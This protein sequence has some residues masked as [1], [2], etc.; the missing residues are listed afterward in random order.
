MLVGLMGATI[1]PL[2]ASKY[3]QKSAEG[4]NSRHQGSYFL[5]S[6]CNFFVSYGELINNQPWTDLIMH[7]FSSSWNR[8]SASIKT[9]SFVTSPYRIVVNGA[10]LAIET[11]NPP[12][13]DIKSLLDRLRSLQIDLSARLP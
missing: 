8:R 4:A 12:A 6:M 2:I 7:T 9:A 3:L 10:V 13:Y 11:Y 1:I 5:D